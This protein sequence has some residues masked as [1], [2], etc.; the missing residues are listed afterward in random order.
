MATVF[1]VYFGANSGGH[2][3]S[4]HVPACEV[5]EL[6]T[7][8]SETHSQLTANINRTKKIELKLAEVCYN[9]KQSQ[10]SYSP[11]NNR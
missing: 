2:D 7:C 9:Y 10:T 6:E 1:A 11:F 4:F 3:F 5:N 8:F